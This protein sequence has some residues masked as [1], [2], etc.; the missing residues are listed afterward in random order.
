MTAFLI[1][2]YTS[3]RLGQLFGSTF[4]MWPESGHVTTSPATLL[5][6]QAL[7]ME[8][9]FTACARE[10]PDYEIQRTIFSLYLAWCLPPVRCPSPSAW[11]FLLHRL[12][13][14]HI[15]LIFFSLWKLFNPSL[16][17]CSW[18]HS[19]NISVPQG[20]V[21]ILFS[22]WSHSFPRCQ[23]WHTDQR[24]P[25]LCLS[26]DL[27]P[28]LHTLIHGSSGK[29]LFDI[30]KPVI[31]VNPK[32]VSPLRFPNVVHSGFTSPCNQDKPGSHPPLTSKIFHLAAENDSYNHLLG[33]FWGVTS[34]MMFG[35]S[36][37]WLIAF[38]FQSS[39]W[40]IFL[41]KHFRNSVWATRERNS[42][43]H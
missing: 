20:S 42:L 34:S 37:F 25:H 40:W 32:S 1:S 2:H 23:P 38:K 7:F 24:C 19:L 28:E 9:A 22:E 36:T 29:Q 5:I 15:S 3:G 43:L 26:A 35:L 13:T 16:S 21:L 6:P 14:Q 10:S 11:N 41:I 39:P 12:P 27:C 30:P 31:L 17:D 4:K 33:Q 8:T 18:V